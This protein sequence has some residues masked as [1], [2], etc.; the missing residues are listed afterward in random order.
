MVEVDRDLL[1]L[2]CSTLLLK[3]GHLEQT[4]HDRVQMAFEYL[5]GGRVCN[6]PGQPVP[7]LISCT[8]KNCLLC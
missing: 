2:S 6:L 4:A 3:K 1:R 8:L 5:Q 7:V